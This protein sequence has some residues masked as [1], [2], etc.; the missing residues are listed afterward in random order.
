M[1]L[2]GANEVGLEVA[3]VGQQVIGA[4]KREVVGIGEDWIGNATDK[5][6]DASKAFHL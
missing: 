6:L 3:L 4:S 1:V 5:L 2:G